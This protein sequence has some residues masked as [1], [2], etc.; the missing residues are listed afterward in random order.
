MLHIWPGCFDDLCGIWYVSYGCHLRVSSARFLLS[1]TLVLA[2]PP[3]LHKVMDLGHSVQFSVLRLFLWFPGVFSFRGIQ[4]CAIARHYSVIGTRKLPYYDSFPR[5]LAS[6]VGQ[7]PAN[8]VSPNRKSR[9]HSD[10]MWYSREYVPYH[11]G[12]IGVLWVRLILLAPPVVDIR[13]P[14]FTAYLHAVGV[15]IIKISI[16]LPPV[17]WW[18]RWLIQIAP[19][20]RCK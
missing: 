2:A 1:S 11:I 12:K 17:L 13:Q 18:F 20:G 16:H 8:I 10:T 9:L 3:Y 15:V 19:C 7:T 4:D 5:C 6:G 14:N